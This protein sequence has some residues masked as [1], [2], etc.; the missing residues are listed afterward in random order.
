M[1]LSL[2]ISDLK[3]PCRDIGIF[4]APL[5]NDL[6]LLWEDGVKVYDAH[7]VEMFTLKAVLLWTINDFPA[8]G[9][10]S[11]CTIK[12]YK[13]CPICSDKTFA[14]RLQASKKEAYMGHRR[15]L[16]EGHK[17]RRQKKAFNGKIENG[18]PP[19]PLTGHEV[20]SIVD[21][22]SKIWDKKQKK[23]ERVNEDGNQIVFNK[24]SILFELQYWEFL[25]KRHCLDVMHI[26]KK[27]L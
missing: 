9:N 4:L 7:A 23:R 17:F 25:Y 18:Q 13:A 15:F 14:I 20:L 16:P 1:M 11:G 12:G 22:I 2:L 3:Q 10:L 8:Y 24:K 5:I 21:G 6:K 26:E 19:N 27:C